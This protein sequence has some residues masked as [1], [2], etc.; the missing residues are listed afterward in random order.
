MDKVIGKGVELEYFALNWSRSSSCAGCRS[1]SGELVCCRRGRVEAPQPMLVDDLCRSALVV[2]P[3]TCLLEWALLSS[4]LCR[5]PTPYHRLCLGVC[6]V[7][8]DFPRCATATAPHTCTCVPPLMKSHTHWD[9]KGPLMRS[10]PS[11]VSDTC[12]SISLRPS[13]SDTARFQLINYCL[14]VFALVLMLLHT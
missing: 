2:D 11:L 12:L 9:R 10:I 1:A 14:F 4:I 3:S 8:L 5:F 7:T 6:A 13:V